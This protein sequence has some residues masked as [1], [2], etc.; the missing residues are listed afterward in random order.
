[1]SLAATTGIV[2]A[3]AIIMGLAPARRREE[4]LGGALRSG[5]RLSGGGHHA[6]RASLVVAEVALAVLL[7]VSAGLMGKSLV[8][9]L[10]VNAGFDATHLL[11]LEINSTGANYRTNESIYAYHDRVRE[12]VGAIPGVRSVAVSNQIPLGGNVD[13]YGV[14]DPENV[15]ANPELAPSG[16]RYTVSASYLGT[17][18]IPVLSGRGFTASDIADTTNKIALVSAALAQRLWPNQSALGKRVRVGGPDAPART[19]VGVTGNVRHRGLDAVMTQQLYMPERQ[20]FF[21]DNQEILIVRTEGDPAA[22]AGSVRRA[23]AAIDPTQ[24]IIKIAT[25]DHV[26]AASTSQRRL[27]LVLFGA[28]AGAALLLAIAGIYG[29]LAGS[30]AERTREIGVRSA[31]GATPG[32]I[33]ALVVGQGGRLAA[34]GIVLGLAGSF[35]LTRY[36]QSLLFGIAPNDPATL[37]GVCVLLAGVTLAACLIPA[38]RAARVDPSTALRSE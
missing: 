38:A 26:V 30:V 5:R 36:L 35:A 23:V 25:M 3:L 20:M 15:P 12:A 28:F 11:T 10:G 19:I 37:A 13:M 18:R 14:I 34:V 17:M 1:T 32:D 27:A 9:L 6:T 31:L 8:R 4:D 33:V 7:L 16:D 29:V 24:P 22:I 2:L 21:A